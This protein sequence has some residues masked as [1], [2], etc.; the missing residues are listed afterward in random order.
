M[1]KSVQLRNLFPEQ[2]HILLSSLEK[3]IDDLQ[4]IRIRV[5]CPCMF[6][7]DKNEYYPDKN[8]M[9]QQDIKQ[10]F[11]FSKEDVCSVFNHICKYSPYAYENQLRQGYLTVEGGHRVGV[12]GQVIMQDRNICSIKQIHFLHIR[13]SHEKMG[14]GQELLP[15][16][17]RGEKFYNTLIVSAP[18][19]G[20]TT[21]LRDLT[22][23]ISDG[24]RFCKGKQVCIV[25]ERSE[26]AG[27]FMGV[28]QNHVG[29][30]TDVL[31]GCPK[32][33]GMMM[34]IRS[35]GPEILVVDELGLKQDYA[36]VELA[37]VCGIRML[38]TVHGMGVS[39]ILSDY[40]PYSEFMKK[41][42][43]RFIELSWYIDP[44]GN[45]KQVWTVYDVKQTILAKRGI[46]I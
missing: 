25:D 10:G 4:E 44:N 40:N 12:C 21:M 36:A 14:I 38:A 43:E 27:C 45:K 24:N 42:F 46:E 8:G 18:G 41:V 6:I 35:M 31:D 32:A 3:V 17:Y 2:F 30:R 39:D 1:N 28:P 16:L 11:V 5:L 23:Y 33:Q 20:K 7:I 34:A 9:L 22:R 29:L 37:G 19:V 15:H 13:I 26:I